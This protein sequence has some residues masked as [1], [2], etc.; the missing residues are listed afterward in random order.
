MESDEKITRVFGITGR[1]RWHIIKK[2]DMTYCRGTAVIMRIVH[3]DNV[4]AHSICRH[5]VKAYLD[6]P[7]FEMTFNMREED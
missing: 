6:D 5:C 4:P 2:S 1:G 3:L 7:G